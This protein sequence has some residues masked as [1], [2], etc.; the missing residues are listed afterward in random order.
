MTAGLPNQ[1]SWSDS[2][3]ES[4]DPDLTR[5]I[6]KDVVTLIARSFLQIVRS[7]DI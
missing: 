2:R 7:P 5:S 6:K 1:Q 3:V 4:R